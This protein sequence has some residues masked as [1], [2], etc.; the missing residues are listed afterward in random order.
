MRPALH[1]RVQQA[2]RRRRGDSS[3]RLGRRVTVQVHGRDDQQGPEGKL[4]RDGVVEEVDG[5]NAG[6]DD[7]ERRGKPF[8]NVV[9]VAHHHG[10]NETPDG[11]LDHHH[12]HQRGIPVEEPILHHDRAV[13]GQH[14]D[15]SRARPKDPELHVPHPYGGVRFLEDHLKV[16]PGETR[17]DA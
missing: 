2:T 6:E 11:L 12:P 13:L 5:C 4:E 3:S 10:H 17:R 15:H 9:R 16:D 14:A 8:E 1:G 7:G